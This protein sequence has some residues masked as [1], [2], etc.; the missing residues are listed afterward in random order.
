MHTEIQQLLEERN[1]SQ[2]MIRALQADVRR[3]KAGQS[4][5]LVRL[6]QQAEA[7][8]LKLESAN[9]QVQRP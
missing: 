6:T 7:L 5:E 9:Q 1:Q 4:E 2:S 8:Q 3:L